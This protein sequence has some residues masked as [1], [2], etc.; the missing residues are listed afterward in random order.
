MV[1]H[2][3]NI[4]LENAF[5]AY[6]QGRKQETAVLIDRFCSFCVSKGRNKRCKRCGLQRAL[7]ILKGVKNDD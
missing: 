7:N 2:S 1:M 6:Q 4:L 5:Q 3:N